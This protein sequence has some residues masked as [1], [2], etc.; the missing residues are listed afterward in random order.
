MVATALATMQGIEADMQGRVKKL[1]IEALKGGVYYSTQFYQCLKVIA[2]TSS[3]VREVAQAKM[4]LGA[5]KLNGNFHH[6]LAP[7]KFFD[8]LS[9]PVTPKVPTGKM[10][11]FYLLKRKKGPSEGAKPSEGMEALQK[12]PTFFDCGSLCN[13]AFF[14]A[15]KKVFKDKFDTYFAPDSKTPLCFSDANKISVLGLLLKFINISSVEDIRLGQRVGIKGPKDYGIKHF[16]G[17]A[18]NFNTL[19]ADETE[20]AKK[21]VGFGL[22]ERALTVHQV[23][24]K[25]H[26]G[27]NANPLGND[28]VT[29]EV[30]ARIKESFGDDWKRIESLK[31]DQM[32]S[33]EFTRQG[34]GSL[35]MVVTDFNIDRI[36]QLVQATKEEGRRLLD[37]WADARRREIEQGSE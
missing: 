28:F 24:K 29:E 4:L 27:Y 8:Y 18:A 26:E 11:N 35:N 14:A 7:T 15:F 31:S 32:S 22:G 9:Q 37:T 25:L 10:V 17:S 23:A 30:A 16:N 13:F 34:G 6:G 3:D 21:F 19:C 36:W 12:G 20:G 5:L 2:E 1:S 33:R